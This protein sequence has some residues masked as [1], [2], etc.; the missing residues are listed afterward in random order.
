[1][2]IAL[3]AKAMLEEEL[4]P[5]WTK[6]RDETCGG[7]YGLVDFDL[8]VHPHAEKGC[9]LNSRI[10]WFFSEAALLT[11]SK[12]ARECADHA[13]L[14]LHEK[15]LDRERGGLYW[16][17][18]YDGQPLDTTKHTYNQAFG[19]YALASYYRLSG[20][21]Q[22]IALAMELF[23]LIETRCTDEEG[24]LEAFTRDWK[25]ESNEKLSENGIIAAKTMNTLLHVLEGYS[26][27]YQAYPNAAVES[28]LRRI[29]ALY[30]DR[31][32]DPQLQRLNVFFDEHYRSLLDLHSYGHDIE[33]SWLTDWGAS[34]LHDENLREKISRLNQRLAE[35][36]YRL[37]YRGHSVMNECERGRVD[38][39][40]VWWV[41][42]EAILGFVHAWEKTGDEKYREAVREIWRYVRETMIDKRPGSEWFWDV[43]ESGVPQSRK[44][45]VEPWKCPYHNGRM[46]LELIRKNPDIELTF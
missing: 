17:V 34:L 43:D 6:L 5:F 29:L 41:Q 42:A 25:P 32:Y 40:R 37:A 2:K 24:Y 20:N 38:A 13:W 14:F 8:K 44:P 10:L 18:A 28:A 39:T 3:A 4:L 19:I 26:G 1:M 9:I 46:C 23:H 21:P 45:I 36:V 16:S 11:N 30:A 7:F 12:A 35:N 31:I 27:L 33:A 22:A 15:C